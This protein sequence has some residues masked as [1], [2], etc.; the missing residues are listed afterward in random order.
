MNT[1]V[2]SKS[3]VGFALVTLLAAA[4]VVLTSMTGIF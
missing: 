1:N 4:S 3:G 2:A